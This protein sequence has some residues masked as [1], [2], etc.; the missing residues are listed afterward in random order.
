MAAWSHE[1]FNIIASPISGGPFS[2]T[3]SLTSLAS[4]VPEITSNLSIVND[5]GDP[6][7]RGEPL[8]TSKWYEAPL[9]NIHSANFWEA[10]N[11]FLLELPQGPT[12]A[13]LIVPFF[14]GIGYLLLD[15]I[16]F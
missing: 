11:Q 14:E 5:T 10:L 12:Y 13:I 6:I 15:L 1:Q 9:P 2:T 16:F 4:N 8:K 7:V 3:S